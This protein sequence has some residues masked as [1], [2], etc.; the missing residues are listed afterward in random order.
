MSQTLCQLGE[1]TKT[2]YEKSISVPLNFLHNLSE[3]LL[4]HFA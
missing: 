2:L 3:P 1:R 4:S